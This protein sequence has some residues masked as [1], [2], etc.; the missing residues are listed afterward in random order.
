MRCWIS[1]LVGSLCNEIH[2]RHLKTSAR[3]RLKSLARECAGIFSASALVSPRLLQSRRVKLNIPMVS[4]VSPVSRRSAYVTPVFTSTSAG[5]LVLMR[6]ERSALRSL[7]G[8]A[9]HCV[10]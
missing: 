8:W 10:R 4:G 1:R 3:V 2:L 5:Q 6:S 7:T 9:G